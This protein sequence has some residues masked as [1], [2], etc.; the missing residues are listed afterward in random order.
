MSGGKFRHIYCIIF[1]LGNRNPV[2]IMTK[3]TQVESGFEKI[4]D[5]NQFHGTWWPEI[6]SVNVDKNKHNLITLV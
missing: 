5:L 1:G 4:R 2:K 3:E 6:T